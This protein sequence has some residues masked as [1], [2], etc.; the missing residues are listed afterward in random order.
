MLPQSGDRVHA[1][2]GGAGGASARSGPR[3]V[4]TSRH[5][6]RASSCGCVQRSAGVFTSA[7]ARLAASSFAAACSAVSPDRA[8]RISAATSSRRSV[9]FAFES[10][11]GSVASEASPRIS[12][13]NAAHSRSFW[14]PI[15][16]VRPSPHS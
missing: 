12:R 5:R 6:P 7:V 10:K 15:I 3:S 4:P 13:Q 11:R 9:R 2:I 1:R 8:A 16:T 14:S